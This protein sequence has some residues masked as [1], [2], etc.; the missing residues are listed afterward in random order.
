MITAN[1]WVAYDIFMPKCK[2]YL[3]I[4]KRY[5]FIMIYQKSGLQ[6]LKRRIKK[7]KK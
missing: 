6:P 7:A 4:V 1:D 5:G 3:D 2:P